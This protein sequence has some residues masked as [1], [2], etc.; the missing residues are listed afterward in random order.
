MTNVHFMNIRV[1]KLL[2]LGLL[3]AL[4]AA[5]LNA[6][7]TS[8]MTETWGQLAIL[9]LSGGEVLI[10]GAVIVI[11]FSIPIILVSIQLCF[12]QEREKMLQET[13]RSMIEKGT[14]IP[15]ELFTRAGAGGNSG[16]LLGPRHDLRNGLLLIGVG[17]GTVIVG[18]PCGWIIFCLGLAFVVASLFERKDK[19]DGQP[20]KI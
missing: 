15:P 17:I 10:G 18:Y 14:P 9:G 1:Y 8:P 12:R 5:P 11:L 4:A 6:Q 3:P 16:M 19:S 20:P 7:S 13:I 2:G